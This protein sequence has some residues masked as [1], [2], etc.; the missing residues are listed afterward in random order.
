MSL[1]KKGAVKMKHVLIALAIVAL[2]APA[3]AQGTNPT[4]KAF[5]HLT[6]DTSPVVPTDNAGVVNVIASPTPYV[7]YRAYIGLTDLSTGFTVIS[8]RLTK[9]TDTCPGVFA[10]PS[11][12]NLMPGD[13]AIGNIFDNTYPAGPGGITIA[14]TGCLDAPLQMIG[15]VSLFYLGG[16]CD[17][18][19][20]DHQHYPR[21]VVDCTEP[22]GLVD[23]YCVWKNAS[24][25]GTPPEGDAGCTANVPVETETWGMI[26]SLYR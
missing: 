18:E 23:Y 24:F 20:L 16:T 13:L 12:T 9:V 19:I 25:G 1:N 22:D 8:I 4:V 26:K 7:T 17:I 3:F 11:F 5:I 21:W 2:C 14:S 6:T 15:Y 10:P